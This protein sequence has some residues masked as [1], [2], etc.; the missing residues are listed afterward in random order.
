[1]IMK[2]LSKI[3]GKK[4]FKYFVEIV[5]FEKIYLLFKV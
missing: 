3:L 4:Y 2:S 1:M 5:F